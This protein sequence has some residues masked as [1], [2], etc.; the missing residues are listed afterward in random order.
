VSALPTLAGHRNRSR[1]SR[2]LKICVEEVRALV[3]AEMAWQE[4][5]ESKPDPDDAVED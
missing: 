2:A 4:A 3:D 5:E 1:L